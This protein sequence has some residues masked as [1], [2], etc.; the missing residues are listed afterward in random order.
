MFIKLQFLPLL[1]FFPSPGFAPFPPCSPLTFINKLVES[2]NLSSDLHPYYPVPPCQYRGGT[3]EALAKND[4]EAVFIQD[5]PRHIAYEA[6]W[7]A[8]TGIPRLM[9][10]LHGNFEVKMDK[11]ILLEIIS[12]R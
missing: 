6:A 2:N 3:L 4:L 8:G 12:G 1:G 11:N 7:A 5:I 10:V 9:K